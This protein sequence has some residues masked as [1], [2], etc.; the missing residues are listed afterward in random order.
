MENL[1]RN[2]QVFVIERESPM[3]RK[4]GRVVTNGAQVAVQFHGCP[5]LWHF[6]RRWL[7][8]LIY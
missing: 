6:A 1:K 5:R 4:T 2:D 7:L 3:Y 8:K